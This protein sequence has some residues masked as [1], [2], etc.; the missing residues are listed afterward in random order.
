MEVDDFLTSADVVRPV[1][2]VD[3]GL[4]KIDAEVSLQALMDD[5]IAQLVLPKYA[6]LEIKTF[7]L[8][9]H[10]VKRFHLLHD[11]MKRH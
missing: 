1:Y 4:E 6:T 9:R 2:S 5:M 10:I 8:Q 7:E 3:A 11:L